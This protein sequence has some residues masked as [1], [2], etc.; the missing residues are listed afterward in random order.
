[1]AAFETSP[2]TV[3]HKDTRKWRWKFS[4]RLE[5]EIV[6]VGTEAALVV[7]PRLKQAK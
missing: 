7:R 6:H 5:W 2:Q 3:S 4:Q 1:M